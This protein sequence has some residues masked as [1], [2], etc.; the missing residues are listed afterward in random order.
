M[1]IER[2]RPW[3][4][5]AADPEPEHVAEDDVELA[6]IAGAALTVGE[7]ALVRPVAGDLLATLG[8][9]GLR[10]PGERHDYPIDLA[11]AHLRPE[12][13][14][15]EQGPFPFVAHLTV[16]PARPT[17]AAAPLGLVGGLVARLFEHGP[18]IEVS[19]MNAAWLGELRLGP[20]AHPNDGL[21]DITEG[22]VVFR[23]RREAMKRARS[24]SHVPHPALRT[25]R[26][27]EWQAS[28]DHPRTIR[29][30]GTDRGRFCEVRVELVPDALVV[31]A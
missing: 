17:G 22:R 26:S 2:G 31:V 19:V 3:G 1:T 27:A 15:P 7:S 12:P 10:Q 13:G 11:L 29:I 20:R 8:V 28:F 24:G 5:P 30:D 18:D 16:S 6:A 23:E 21:L 14:Q 25:T 9:D 4:S